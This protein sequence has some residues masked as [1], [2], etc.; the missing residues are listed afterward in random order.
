MS[1]LFKNQDAGWY[2]VPNRRWWVLRDSQNYIKK[3]YGLVPLNSY[4][5]HMRLHQR[6][7]VVCVCRQC[8]SDVVTAINELP[9]ET[10]DTIEKLI[11]TAGMTR[12]E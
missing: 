9:G 10:H 5:P 7:Y 8:V 12:D 6:R 11:V 2:Q 3:V 1:G 4:P